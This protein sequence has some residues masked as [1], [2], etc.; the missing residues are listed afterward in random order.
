[1]NENKLPEPEEEIDFYI[2]EWQRY[3][4][5]IEVEIDQVIGEKE[6]FEI[7]DEAI[8]L[9]KEG[10][11]DGNATIVYSEKIKDIALDYK[12]DLPFDREAW[13]IS[14]CAELGLKNDGTPLRPWEKKQPKSQTKI[15]M[16]SRGTSV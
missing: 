4:I 1:M 16:F 6:D 8:R 15:E 9:F 2:D 3:T 11:V 14:K 12:T 13:V 10:V 5:T 7:C